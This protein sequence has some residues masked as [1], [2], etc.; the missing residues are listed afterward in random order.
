LLKIIFTILLLTSVL[1][2]E[3]MFV[4][5]DGTLS[6]YN[7]TQIENGND[8]I[9]NIPIQNIEIEKK[10]TT[11][12]YKKHETKQKRAHKK[13]LITSSSLKSKNNKTIY[14]TFD[15]GPL[16]GTQNIISI[17]DQTKTPATMFMI[18][19]HIDTNSYREELF[20]RAIDIP[21]IFVANHTYSHANG[22]YRRFYS[23]SFKVVNDLN[24][25]EYKL[26]V[27]DPFHTF[28]CCRLAGRNVFRIE[29]IKK[30]DPAIKRF[31]EYKTYDALEDNGYKIFGWDCEYSYNPKNG[32]PYISPQLLVDNIEKIY[33]SG[34]TKKPNKLILLMHDFEFQNRFNG[35]KKLKKLISLLQKN[36][37]SFETLESY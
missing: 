10:K 17:L 33:K 13:I 11:K 21:N 23:N 34:K 5:E 31:K 16:N 29:G 25:M 8:S 26:K 14:L 27:Y 32:R 1:F 7:N 30:N 9:Y 20:L 28:K 24:E 36:G 6:P 3:W 18:G 2:G 22:Q 15:D 4:N 37:W 12:K 35:K 19:K